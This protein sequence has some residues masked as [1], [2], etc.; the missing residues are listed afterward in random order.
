MQIKP[1]ILY[2]VNVNGYLCADDD[3]KYSKQLFE[4]LYQSNESNN[5]A[6]LN[7]TDLPRIK[8]LAHAHGWKVVVRNVREDEMED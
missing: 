6:Y 5:W 1:T 7:M 4:H 8:V 3:K 2:L